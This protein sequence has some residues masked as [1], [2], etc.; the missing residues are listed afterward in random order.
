MA[1]LHGDEMTKITNRIQ[2]HKFFRKSKSENGRTQMYLQSLTFLVIGHRP[3]IDS[4]LCL[5]RF[6][7]ASTLL[8]CYATCTFPARYSTLL[9][10]YVTLFVRYDTLLAHYNTLLVRYDSFLY[11]TI[12]FL[13]TTLRFSC[14]TSCTFIYIYIYINSD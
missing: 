1:Q 3:S 4:N 6:S 13:H 11:A 14:Y 2:S 8:A 7:H 9:A 12:R 10:R 5:T